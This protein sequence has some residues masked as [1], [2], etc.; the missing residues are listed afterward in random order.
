MKNISKKI[1]ILLNQYRLNLINVYLLI[2]MSEQAIRRSIKNLR[3]VEG[4]E[5]FLFK[6]MITVFL[7]Y[8]L[9]WGLIGGSFS[10]LSFL[11][12]YFKTTF[13]A[14]LSLSSWAQIMP[15][16]AVN[17]ITLILLV[18]SIRDY[19]KSRNFLTIKRLILL[20]LIKRKEVLN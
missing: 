11:D 18:D 7:A 19:I 4:L 16:I 17:L 10:E 8:F 5:G 13:F 2:F 12:F 15:I 3:R 1:R 6:Y 20:K 14:L 9:Y